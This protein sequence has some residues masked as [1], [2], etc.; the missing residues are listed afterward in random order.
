V[1]SQLRA[2]LQQILRTKALSRRDEEMQLACGAMSRDFIDGKEALAAWRDLKVACDAIVEAV[3]AAGIEFDAA[4]GLTLGADALAVGIAAVSDKQ[5]F[6]VR[7]QQ[8]GRGTMRRIEGLQVGRGD[9]VLLVEDVVTTGGSILDA[10]R[11]VRQTGAEV[12]AAVTLADR[13]DTAS[14]AFADLG[15]PYF[16]MATYT[17][18]G[19]DPVVPPADALPTAG[20]AI[21]PSAEPAHNTTGPSGNA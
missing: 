8:K 9:R 12:V 1:P 17:D 10:F 2:G 16:A 4:G 14:G 11:V 19:I 21:A 5:W 15:V 7:K 13:G 3:G 20:T 6:I 18:L